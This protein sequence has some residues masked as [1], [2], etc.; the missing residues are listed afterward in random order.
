MFVSLFYY[1]KTLVQARRT[2]TRFIKLQR[3]KKM[4]KITKIFLLV[5]SFFI[6]S[7]V[8][9]SQPV[10]SKKFEFSTS[11]SIW[12]VKFRDQETETL[13][14]IPIRLGFF[15]YKGLEI[16]P[17]L[18]LTIPEG[19]DLGYLLLASVSYNFRIFDKFIPF[20]LAGGGYGNSEQSF[21]VAHDYGADIFAIHFGG[22]I[23]YLVSDSAALRMDYR[24]T[25]Y[26]AEGYW[27][28]RTDNN[29]FFGLSIFF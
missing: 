15:I 11:A 7:E 8:I 23:K 22:G 25:K 2:L 21:S 29:V 24:F 28:D 18:F 16:E 26:L 6:L 19:E 13:V 9:F 27:L 10:Q 4:K 14:N 12:N 20:I 3:R 17:E 1:R 5:L